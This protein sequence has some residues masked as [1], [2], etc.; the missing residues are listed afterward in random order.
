MQRRPPELPTGPCGAMR[1][2]EGSR[3]RVA[4]PV[5]R[6][7]GTCRLL[8]SASTAMKRHGGFCQK[9]KRQRQ[10]WGW[11]KLS[12][13]REDPCGG[14][15]MLPSRTAAT[16]PRQPAVAPT[17]PANGGRRVGRPRSPPRG[18]AGWEVPQDASQAQ[19]NS[20]PPGENSS[21]PAS[22]PERRCA[23]PPRGDHRVLPRGTCAHGQARVSS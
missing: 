9:T 8:L 14:S 6:A 12:A 4:F 22:P 1:G 2:A 10:S 5:R 19:D 13:A 3:A 23:L 17:R 20:W 15:R 11:G 21:G 18:R 7:H 16:H